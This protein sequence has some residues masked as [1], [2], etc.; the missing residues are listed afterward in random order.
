MTDDLRTRIAAAIAKA[1]QDWC[2]DNNL[3]EDMADAA[4]R[5][6]TDAIPPIVATAI[7]GYAQS[8]LAAMSYH[9]GSRDAFDVMEKMNREALQIANY[10]TT[11]EKWNGPNVKIRSAEKLGLTGDGE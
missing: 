8:E 2:S 1:D 9:G 11:H 6:L 5:E 10:A 3:Y 4:I 7:Q